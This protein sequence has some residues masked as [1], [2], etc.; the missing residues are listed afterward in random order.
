MKRKGLWAYT[1]ICLVLF[2]AYF[3]VFVTLEKRMMANRIY[4]GLTDLIQN[5]CRAEVKID[6]VRVLFQWF[7]SRWEAYHGRERLY[8]GGLRNGIASFNVPED[9]LNRCPDRNYVWNSEQR[10]FVPSVSPHGRQSDDWSAYVFPGFFSLIGL[11]VGGWIIIWLRGRPRE[12][13]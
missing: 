7:T 2:V 3:P 6:S 8:M 11:G 13:S 10:A 12:P 5:E 9:L 4:D 1:L